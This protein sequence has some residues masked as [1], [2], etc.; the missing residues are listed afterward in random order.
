MFCVVILRTNRTRLFGNVT[1]CLQ[2]KGGDLRFQVRTCVF[3]LYH[4]SVF[5][6]TYG[7][8][9]GFIFLRMNG[10]RAWGRKDNG[11]N[12]GTCFSYL[13]GQTFFIYLG[14]F[15]TFGLY[16]KTRNRLT[17]F[18]FSPTG[19]KYYKKANLV[20]HVCHVNNIMNMEVSSRVVN[21]CR[22]CFLL[23]GFLWVNLLPLGAFWVRRTLAALRTSFLRTLPR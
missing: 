20:G 16:I 4:Q 15:A 12:C 3:T 2:R 1:I 13:W 5:F 21:I 19:V 11:R 8:F 18:F 17:L 7:T 10:R 9:Y 23:F 22:V 6:G 14:F